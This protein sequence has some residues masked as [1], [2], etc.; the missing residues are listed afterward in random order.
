MRGTSY[1]GFVGVASFNHRDNIADVP[2]GRIWYAVR[3]DGGQVRLYQTEPGKRHA[4]AFDD[5]SILRRVIDGLN[6]AL[7]RMQ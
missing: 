3:I 1:R 6:E 2:Y 4:I 5:P 7:R